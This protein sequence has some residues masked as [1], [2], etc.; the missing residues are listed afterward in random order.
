MVEG[1]KNEVHAVKTRCDVLEKTVE[2]LESLCEFQQRNLETF[3][4]NLIGLQKHLG[5]LDLNYEGEAFELRQ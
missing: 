1:L 2:K 3:R 4:Q 5:L